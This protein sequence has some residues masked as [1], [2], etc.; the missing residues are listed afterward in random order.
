M[1]RYGIDL[2]HHNIITDWNKVKKQVDFIILKLGNIGDD[3]KFWKDAKF[4]ENYNT[5]IKLNIPVGVYVYCY[6][7]DI[8]NIDECAKQTLAFLNKRKLQ[9]PVYIDMEDKEIAGEGKTKLTNIVFKYN[10]L[11]E[12]GG[13]WAGVYANRNWFDNY[14]DKSKIKKRFTTWIATYTNGVGKYKGEYDIWQNSEKG[15][16]DGIRGNVDTNYMY[17]DLMAEIGNM[18]Q[19]DTTQRTMSVVDL[20]Y[21]VIK[22]KYGVGEARKKALGSLYDDVQAK[23]NEILKVKKK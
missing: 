2:S 11:I 13:Y 3:K 21:D 16:I 7:N 15:R 18:S 5:C 10:E 8:K 17:R 4:E 23:V 14:L 20:A 6:T 1:S 9:L 12:K 19:S 22:G